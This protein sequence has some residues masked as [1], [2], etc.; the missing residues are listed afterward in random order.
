M[1]YYDYLKNKFPQTLRHVGELVF[2]LSLGSLIIGTGDRVFSFSQIP[3]LSL[4][5]YLAVS[6]FLVPGY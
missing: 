3:P 5:I 4:A 1:T 6:I 2:G